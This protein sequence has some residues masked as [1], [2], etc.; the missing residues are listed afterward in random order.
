MDKTKLV[1]LEKY[2]SECWTILYEE[3][4]GKS[5]EEKKELEKIRDGINNLEVLLIDYKKQ[6][7]V[8]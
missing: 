7:E 6:M 5:W 1:I 8:K 2:L 3:S 4:L